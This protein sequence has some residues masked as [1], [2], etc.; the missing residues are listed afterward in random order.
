MF[1]KKDFANHLKMSSSGLDK[2]RSKD[3]RFPIPMRFGRSLRWTQDQVEGYVKACLAQ[4]QAAPA[5]AMPQAQE[6]TAPADQTDTTG[7]AM[8]P[9]PAD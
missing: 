4:A 7:P 9:A 8:L 3:P 5:P 2:V 1:D 6:P